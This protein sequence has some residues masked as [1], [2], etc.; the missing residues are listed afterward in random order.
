M[1]FNGKF[2]GGVFTPSKEVAEAKLFEFKDLPVLPDSQ[3]MFIER[4]LHH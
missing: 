1:T 3:L 4:A 2:I